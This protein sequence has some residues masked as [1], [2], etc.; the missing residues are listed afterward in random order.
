M[1]ANPKDLL[2][3]TWVHVQVARKQIIHRYLLFEAAYSLSADSLQYADI[4]TRFLNSNIWLFSA[5]LNIN[6]HL[7]FEFNIIYLDLYACDCASILSE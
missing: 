5:S 7:D 3:I 6:L 4:T 1:L 2:D